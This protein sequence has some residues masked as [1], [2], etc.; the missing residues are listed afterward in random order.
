MPEQKIIKVGWEEYVELIGEVFAQ[1]KKSG[2]EPDYL[3]AI[4][5]RAIDWSAFV[6][7]V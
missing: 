6:L 4:A 2:F 1:V 3:V 5:R 7:F